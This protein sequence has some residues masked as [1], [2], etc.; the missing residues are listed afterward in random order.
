MKEDILYFYGFT[1]KYNIYPDGLQLSSFSPQCG[2]EIF[3]GNFSETHTLRFPN[4][5]TINSLW[6]KFT[7]ELLLKKMNIKIPNR[8]PLQ[9]KLLIL[10]WK[11]L[12]PFEGLVYWKILN[13]WH[14]FENIV[15]SQ[16]RNEKYGEEPKGNVSTESS[17]V[18]SADLCRRDQ[19]RS[20]VRTN[21]GRAGVRSRWTLRS[22]ENIA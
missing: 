9:V 12:K 11:H 21:I 16:K 17:R 18:L 15:M 6:S 14:I 1:V 13:K 19:Q 5:Y 10:K 4:M 20:D 22:T 3:R 7:F 8:L 2:N